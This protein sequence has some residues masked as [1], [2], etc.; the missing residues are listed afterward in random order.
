MQRV[1]LLKNSRG[2]F[3]CIP[4]FEVRDLDAAFE[5]HLEYD[6]SSFSMLLLNITLRICYFILPH[7][8]VLMWRHRWSFSG[9]QFIME[10]DLS[11]RICYAPN[12]SLAMIM[13]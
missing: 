1:S 5:L 2:H 9:Q 6:T 3:N 11:H 13:E 10:I 12:L 7:R 8:E 4:T